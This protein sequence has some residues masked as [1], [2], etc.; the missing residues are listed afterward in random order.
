MEVPKAEASLLRSGS[1]P[2]DDTVNHSKAQ[3]TAQGVENLRTAEINA[4]HEN[5]YATSAVAKDITATNACQ[6]LS[7]HSQR[8]PIQKTRLTLM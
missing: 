8:R 5:R 4:L 3:N 7:R 6:K 1:D 2:H